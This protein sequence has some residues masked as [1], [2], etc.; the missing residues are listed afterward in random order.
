MTAVR[1]IMYTSTECSPTY[2]NTQHP[3]YCEHTAQCHTSTQY[4]RYTSHL[5][6]IET[7]HCIINSMPYHTPRHTISE[8]P[9]GW[10]TPPYHNRYTPNTK[11]CT[12]CTVCQTV[13]TDV[14]YRIQYSTPKTPLSIHH[15]AHVTSHTAYTIPAFLWTSKLWKP[16]LRNNTL[17]LQEWYFSS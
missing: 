14:F 4:K 10:Q 11:C 8:L 7:R 12:P 9:L 6:M 1:S 16:K 13:Y 3:T 15:T 2:K 5:T 17:I